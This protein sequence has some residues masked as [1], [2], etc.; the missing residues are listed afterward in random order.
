[1]YTPPALVM[2]P[3]VAPP[4]TLHVTVPPVPVATKWWLAP[5]RIDSVVT[6]NVGGALTVTVAHA[7]PRGLACDAQ[8]LTGDAGAVLGAV[9]VPDP[10]TV[11]TVELPPAMLFTVQVNGPVPPDVTL[12]VVDAPVRK[13]AVVALSTSVVVATLI[14]TVA[15]VIA[16]GVD[17]F[18]HTCTGDVVGTFA[19]AVY[20]PDVLIIPFVASPPV[21]LLTVH[22]NG[23]VPP[24]AV[25]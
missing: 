14:V 2:V 15:H 22:V 24:V 25:N 12:N 5:V 4:V 19:G 17:W 13:A 6:S 20:N 18:T 21:T 10:L 23:A 3:F 7:C 8:T 9:Y 11:P 1:V 16:S